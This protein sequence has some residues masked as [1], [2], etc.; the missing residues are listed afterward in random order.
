MTIRD[1]V[2]RVVLRDPHI[3]NMMI[4]ERLENVRKVEAEVEVGVMIEIVV[5]E[6]EIEVMKM[7][8]TADRVGINSKDMVGIVLIIIGTILSHPP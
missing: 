6:V 3:V 1:V 8:A 4:E 5:G 7:I 2:M